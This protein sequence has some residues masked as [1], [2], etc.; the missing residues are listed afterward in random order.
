MTPE[1]LVQPTVDEV[2]VFQFHW[3]GRNQKANLCIVFID[4]E[5]YVQARDC[6]DALESFFFD[7]F[8]GDKFLPLTA[9][10]SAS[11]CTEYT[12]RQSLDAFSPYFIAVAFRPTVSS[13]ITPSDFAEYSN[14]VV[15]DQQALYEGLHADKREI[16]DQGS[17]AL[18]RFARSKVE[19]NLGET[20]PLGV[21]S[22]DEMH[23]AELSILRYSAA[24]GGLDTSGLYIMANVSV[25]LSS[26]LL[27]LYAYRELVSDEDIIL[28]KQQTL[29]LVRGAAQLNQ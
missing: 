16:I 29:Q 10:I 12:T 1:E 27:F 7:L 14:S 2:I 13:N 5:G 21:F 26:K 23:V 28:V 11:D 25:L 18:S 17:Q 22:L 15:R 24:G 4:I 6:D 3:T 20:I 19:L 9:F 8:S